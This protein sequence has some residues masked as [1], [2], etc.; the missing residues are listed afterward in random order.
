MI[1]YRT[2]ILYKDREKREYLKARRTRAWCKRMPHTCGEQCD[3]TCQYTCT[4]SW[5]IILTALVQLYSSEWIP[6]ET[7]CCWAPLIV[8]RPSSTTSLWITK[9]IC[10]F[11]R[12]L[13]IFKGMPNS[14]S[15]LFQA[16]LLSTWGRNVISTRETNL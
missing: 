12:D 8:P 5:D 11:K 7:N 10:N 4:I 13:D 2:W 9:E 1:L 3:C 6:W 15:S 16:G 14:W